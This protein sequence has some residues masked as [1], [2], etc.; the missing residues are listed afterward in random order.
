MEVRYG[1]EGSSSSRSMNDKNKSH[2]EKQVV[3]S[4]KRDDR[5]DRALGKKLVEIK[6]NQKQS[7]PYAKP[8]LG[9]C[10]R[11]NQPGYKS[12]ECPN[13]RPVNVVERDEEEVCYE[14]D[15]EEEYYEEE[16]GD[17]EQAYVIRKLM[18]APKQDEDTQRHQLFR[19]RCT[20][21]RRVFDLIVDS[22]SCENIIG[23]AVVAQL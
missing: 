5:D 4:E 17:V 7:N 10:Y 3:S 14:P 12:N 1:F 23:R 11:C 21:G 22:G 20:I 2:K 15:G 16:D 9:K 6:D 18:L 8:I 19:I 13:R